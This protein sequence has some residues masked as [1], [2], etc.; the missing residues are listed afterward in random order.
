MTVETMIANLSPEDRRNALELLWAS[1]EK[2]G[3]AYTPPEWHG[4]VLA[5]RL[6]NPSD[7][8]AMPLNEAMK[9]IT[10]RVDERRTSS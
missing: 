5:D 4:Q 8:P 3:D 10:R 1:F 7:K 6:N 9:D 2:E